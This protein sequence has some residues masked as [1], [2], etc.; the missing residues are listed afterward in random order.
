MCP[1]LESRKFCAENVFSIKAGSVGSDSEKSIFPVW[2]KHA[3]SS[4]C[5]CALPSR[6]STTFW[7]LLVSSLIMPLTSWQVSYLPFFLGPLPKKAAIFGRAFLAHDHS[8]MISS[9]GPAHNGTKDSRTDD[10]IANSNH[11]KLD[12]L[13]LIAKGTTANPWYDFYIYIC[14]CIYIYIYL[15]EH[16]VCLYKIFW[17]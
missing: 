2:G 10:S 7:T 3:Y 9:G 13:W 15:Y 4:P 1:S 12:K 17:M 11:G 5:V 14:I 16:T 6:P 8:M